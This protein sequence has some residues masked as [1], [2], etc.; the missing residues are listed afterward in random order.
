MR[1]RNQAGM[2]IKFHLNLATTQRYLLELLCTMKNEIKCV[3]CIKLRKMYS[4]FKF[5]KANI[6]C[7]DKTIFTFAI[8]IRWNEKRLPKK[9]TKYPI[10]NATEKKVQNKEFQI[11]HTV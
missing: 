6:I 8:V 11:H 5:Q 2:S 3:N 7:Q 1:E 4:I 9:H 10:R